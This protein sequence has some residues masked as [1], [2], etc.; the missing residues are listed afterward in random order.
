MLTFKGRVCLVSDVVA[1]HVAVQLWISAL[2]EVH[3]PVHGQCSVGT[4]R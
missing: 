4:G 2:S 1:D 3:V